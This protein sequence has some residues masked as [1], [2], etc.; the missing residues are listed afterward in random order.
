MEDIYER[1][2]AKP[3]PLV[4]GELL[5]A[6]EPTIQSALRSYAGGNQALRSRARK[7]ASQAVQS[8]DPKK[9]AK[10][11]THLMTQM[12]PL[13]RISREYT[14]VVKVP[15]RAT[16]DLYK[17]NQ[18]QQKFKDQFSRD[19][20]DKELADATG[21]SMRRLGKVRGFG[22]GEVAESSLTEMDEGEASVMYPGV[23]KIDPEMVWMEYVHHDLPPIDQQILEW[24]TGYNGKPVLSNNE[25]ARRLNLTAGA[26]SQRSGRIS[27]RL[28]QGRGILK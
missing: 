20:S 12:Q 8:Y 21:M 28:N 26:I 3:S 6:A 27:E 19:P 4:M 18:E 13:T 14:Q 15:E 7:L 16:L 17:L 9:G 5:Q 24:K 11:S 10:L 23:S 25:I 22:R 1:W 2:K